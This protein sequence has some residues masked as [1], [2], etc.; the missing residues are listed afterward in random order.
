MPFLPG[1]SP[2]MRAC[3]SSTSLVLLLFKSLVARLNSANTVWASALPVA[4]PELQPTGTADLT[5]T[6]KPSARP[7]LKVATVEDLTDRILGTAK[8]DPENLDR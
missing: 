3:A 5:C 7:L 8:S 4:A 2:L 1:I 6:R